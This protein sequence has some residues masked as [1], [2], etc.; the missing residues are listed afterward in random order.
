MIKGGCQS[1]RKVVTHNSKSDLPLVSVF[2]KLSTI[3]GLEFFPLQGE[4]SRSICVKTNICRI[5]SL[6]G[7]NRGWDWLGCFTT[8]L[9]GPCW[10]SAPALSA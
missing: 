2:E 10:M 9:S 6:E 8:G 5:F 1:G 4:H 3:Y 7:R